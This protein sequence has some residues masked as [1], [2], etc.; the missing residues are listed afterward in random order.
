MTFLHMENLDDEIMVDHVVD[1]AF[2]LMKDIFGQ[3]Q[4]PPVVYILDSGL[5]YLKNP[6]YDIT[7][8]LDTNTKKFQAHQCILRQAFNVFQAMLSDNYK[9]SVDRIVEVPNIKHKTFVSVMQ[10]VYTERLQYSHI[11][12]AYDILAASNFYGMHS[13]KNICEYLIAREHMVVEKVSHVYEFV[14]RYDLKLLM[15]ARI[16]FVLEFHE[17]ISS[18]PWC[19]T[20]VERNDFDVAANP[21]QWPH[22]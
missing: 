8:L 7:F 13:L 14:D 17:Q 18:L 10:F 15:H 19:Q 5:R 9:H 20:L 11:D 6:N 22:F 2:G 16:L 1:E 4:P 21:L 3:E 12:Y